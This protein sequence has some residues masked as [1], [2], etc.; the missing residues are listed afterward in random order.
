MGQ[1]AALVSL[2]LT[3]WGISGCSAET[4]FGGPDP[5][6][7]AACICHI[8]EASTRTSMSGS[9]A[10]FTPGDT[11][12]LFETLTGRS[13]VPYTLKGA[14]WSTSTPAYWRDGVSTHTFYAYYPYKSAYSGMRISIPVLSGQTIASQPDPKSD[15]LVAGPLSQTRSASVGLTFTHGFALLQLNVK[16]GILNLLNPYNLNRITVRGGNTAGSANRYGIVNT[17]GAPAQVGY[18]L[19]ARSIQAATNDAQSYAQSFYSDITGINLTTTAVTLYAFLLPGTY[20]NP[21]PAISFRL[22]LLGITYNTGFSNFSN[23]TFQAGMKYVYDV[24]IGLLTRSSGPDVT[25]VAQETVP[26]DGA[27]SYHAK[28]I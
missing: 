23:T 1:Y 22:S 25:L 24:S 16:M 26:R 10:S 27:I 19:A 14:S 20:A 21:Q 18:D 9:K 11:I 8:G 28:T 4:E 15:L 2:L 7:V 17:T 6:R 3:A 13:D 12:G 5:V